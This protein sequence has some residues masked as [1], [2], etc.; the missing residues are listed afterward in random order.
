ME[1][2]RRKKKKKGNKNKFK[3]LKKKRKIMKEITN[4]ISGDIMGIV[5]REMKTYLDNLK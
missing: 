1:R 4:K 2:R 5:L 3:K